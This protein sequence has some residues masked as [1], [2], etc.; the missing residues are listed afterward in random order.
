M[1]AAQEYPGIV[2]MVI[3]TD[4]LADILDSYLPQYPVAFIHE[5]GMA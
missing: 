3:F 1:D 4:P 5:Q 2:D